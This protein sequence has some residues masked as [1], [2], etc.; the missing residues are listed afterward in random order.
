MKFDTLSLWYLADPS[1]PLLVGTLRLVM[2][3]RGV[4]L[5]YAPSWRA[6]GF[7]LSED[8]PLVDIEHLPFDRDLAAGAVDDARPDRWGERVIQI[9]EKPSRLSIQEFLYFAGPDRFGA[10]GV[11]TSATEYAPHWIGPL[12]KLSEAKHVRAAIRKIQEKQPIAAIEKRM[13]ASGGSFSGR[14]P[15]ALI[16]VDGAQYLAKFFAGEPV[17]LP[18]VEHAAMTLAK[19]SNIDV[20]ETSLLRLETENA[21]LL[22][23]FDR[24]GERRIHIVSAAVAIRAATARGQQPDFGYSALAQIL[25]RSGVAKGDA[26]KR[27]MA[28]LFRRMVFNI[29]IDNTDDHEKNHALLSMDPRLPGTLRLAPA[30][31]IVPTNS[32]QGRHE[33]RIG[34]TGHDG[35][36]ENAL[37]EHAMFGLSEMQA[38]SQIAIVAAAVGGWKT[39]FKTVGVCDADIDMLA[40][41]IDADDLRLQR[42]EFGRAV[43]RSKPS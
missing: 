13:I 4:S 40:Q 11:S 36:L 26:N 33:F 17:D 8:L 42:R 14:K 1:A 5:E 25:R 18:L 27:D 34:S 3:G 37:S 29:L 39:H 20:A 10:L 7:A 2:N 28:Q 38:R 6:G 24:V 16:D 9:L 22:K 30:Y 43:K 21:L 41:T 12:P 23:R 15:K 35:T 19:T 31:D 32:G